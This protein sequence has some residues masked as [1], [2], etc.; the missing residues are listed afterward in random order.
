[1]LRAAAGSVLY[2]V[3]IALLSLGL[4][5]AVRDSAAAIGLVLG[6]LYVFPILGLAVSRPGLAAAPAAG[7]R[8]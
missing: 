5:T 7:R 8:R 4:A 2:L 1:M 3:L 6:L